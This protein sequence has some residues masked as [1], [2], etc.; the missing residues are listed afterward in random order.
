[1][2]SM[3][4]LGLAVALVM[5]WFA[6]GIIYNLRRG[7]SILRWMRGGLP[8]IGERTTF[9]WLGTSV[10]ELVIAHARPPFRRLETLLVLEPRDVPW[11]WLIARLRGRRDT[12]IWRGQLTNPPQCDLELADPKIWTGQAALKEAAQRG[13][14]SQDYQSLRLMAPAGSVNQALQAAE[15]LYPKAVALNPTV[16]RLSLR[17]EQPHFELHLPLPDTRQAA[18][19]TFAALQSYG[20]AASQR[21]N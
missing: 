3:Y 2:D 7:D 8:K 10:A 14:E 9:R 11:F 12:L 5:S 15:Q 6:I 20:Q 16:W 19:D 18:G 4:W 13:W 1:M 21:F 17:K